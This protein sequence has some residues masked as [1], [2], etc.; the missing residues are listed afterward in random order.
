TSVVGVI[1]LSAALEG[2]FKGSMNSITRIILAIGALLLIYPGLITGLIG[3]VIILGIAALNIKTS[4]TPVL[5]L[6][7]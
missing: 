1:G 2:Y 4:K 3:G 7:I 6:N 5:P